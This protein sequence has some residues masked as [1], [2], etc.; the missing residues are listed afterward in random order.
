MQM[1][2]PSSLARP[3]AGVK[4]QCQLSVRGWGEEGAGA[5]WRDLLSAP[6]PNPGLWGQPPHTRGFHLPGRSPT[7][8]SPSCLTQSGCYTTNLGSSLSPRP[9]AERGSRHLRQRTPNSRANPEFQGGSLLCSAAT[10][11]G[12]PSSGP[13]SGSASTNWGHRTF[14]GTCGLRPPAPSV[15]ACLSEGSTTA[16]PVYFLKLCV[17]RSDW[18][19][20]GHHGREPLPHTPQQMPEMP[21]SLL[22]LWPSGH[23][24]LRMEV[25]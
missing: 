9:P 22:A 11:V 16:I 25:S 20:A 14:P 19:G 24:W 13:A 6:P 18:G 12:L 17:S 15:L 21:L 3:K 5:Q 10:G 4:F 1:R 23:V 8:S 7:A 2:F